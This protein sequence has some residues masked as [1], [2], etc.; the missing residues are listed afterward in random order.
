GSPPLPDQSGSV[1]V[2]RFG[3][4]HA[5]GLHMAMCDGSVQFINYSIDPETHRRL[6]KRNDG[7]PIDGKKF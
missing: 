7:L 2:Y 6:G 5:V 4:A 3:S 1:Q